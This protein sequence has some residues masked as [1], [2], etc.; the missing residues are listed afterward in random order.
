MASAKLANNTVNQSHS[1]ICR[2]NLNAAP[3]LNSSTVVITL[4]IS[5]TNMTGFPIILRGFSLSRASHTALRMIFHSQTAF[6]LGFMGEC[7]RRTLFGSEAAGVCVVIAIENPLKGLARNHEQVLKD[8]AKAQ[9]REKRQR[10]HNQNH[11]N[12][13]HGKKWCRHRESAQ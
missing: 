8:W 3:P 7:P 1:V 5:T 9:C 4:P 10:A 2:L 11:A 13:K 12:Q 6:F